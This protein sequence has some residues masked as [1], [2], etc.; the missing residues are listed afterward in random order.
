MEHNLR[1]LRVVLA[2]VAHSFV[3][4]AADECRVSQPAVTQA[5]SKLER[6]IGGSL[7]KRTPQGL[8]ANELG[9]I[10]ARRVERAFAHL[11]PAIATIAARLRLTMTASQLR[12]LIAVR[13]AE[14]FTLAARRLDRRRWPDDVK[15]RIVVESFA[16]GAVVSGVARRHGLSPQQLFTW[17]RQARR[18]DFTLP[19]ADEAAFVPVVA[20][21][22][23]PL[24]GGS[25]DEAPVPPC[26]EPSQ[27]IEVVLGGAV[28]RVP[29]AVDGKVLATVLRAV[30]A[31][32]WSL[33]GGRFQVF[34]AT[35]PVDF[36]KGMDGLAAVVQ[37][38]LRLDPF[39]GA[40]FVFRAKRGDRAT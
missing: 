24:A 22:G 6:Q 40:V 10:F 27:M 11:D 25:H 20:A 18:G 17:R 38:A 21:S 15:A 31:V 5:L 2:V 3:T 14:N 34:V 13:E 32:V 26:A 39:S 35:R 28:V 16:P 37:E 19:M 29:P 30:K 1:H 7:F 8:F 36:R 12:A 4:R 9:R 23:L 33:P